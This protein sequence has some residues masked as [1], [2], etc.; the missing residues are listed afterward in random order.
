V[1]KGV[2]N[3]HYHR[4]EIGQ[5]ERRHCEQS[6]GA[7]AEVRREAIRSD[8]VPG[9]GLPNFQAIHQQIASFRI[10]AIAPMLLSQ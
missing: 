6:T 5:T 9:S 8:E 4:E 2:D 3:N 1:K 7:I 10:F